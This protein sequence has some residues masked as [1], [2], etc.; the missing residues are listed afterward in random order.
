MKM[1]WTV[2]SNPPTRRGNIQEASGKYHYNSTLA[3]VLLTVENLDLAPH[4]LLVSCR[5]VPKLLPHSVCRLQKGKIP[6]EQ[7]SSHQVV[8]LKEGLCDD[9]EMSWTLLTAAQD[10]LLAPPTLF[11]KEL[12]IIITCYQYSR[13]RRSRDI[14]T[15]TNLQAMQCSWLIT[16]GV[17]LSLRLF[18]FFLSW[19]FQQ[20]ALKPSRTSP[21]QSRSRPRTEMTEPCELKA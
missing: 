15:E 1:R 20:R 21:A 18:F 11:L 17:W 13:H 14:D 2:P 19:S 16:R 9:S 12:H 3:G 10:M 7:M 8:S 6:A 5:T 4:P